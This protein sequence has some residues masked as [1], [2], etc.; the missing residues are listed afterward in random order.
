[1]SKEEVKEFETKLL[2]LFTIKDKESELLYRALIMTLIGYK[3]S[4]I[5]EITLK[6]KKDGIKIGGVINERSSI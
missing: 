4:K 1:M 5:D 3:E 6:I 2:S